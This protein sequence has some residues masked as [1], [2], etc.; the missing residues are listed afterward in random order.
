M[1]PTEASLVERPALRYFGGKWMKGEWIISNFPDHD[2]YVEPTG[3]GAN[4][5][6]RKPR[7]RIEAYNDI[8]DAVV[9]FFRVVRDK[10]TELVEA[11][12]HTP[13]AVS[14]YNACRDQV[15]SD[16]ERA[17]RFF[18]RSWGG[19]HGTNGSGRNRGWRRCATRNTAG[20]FHTVAEHLKRV[21]A[22]LRGV[23]IDCLD[24]LEMVVRWDSLRTLFYFDP[25]YWVPSRASKSPSDGYGPHDWV[26]ADHVKLCETAN[27]IR[28]A[29]VISGY[30]TPL[31]D[32]MLQGFRRIE[33]KG[34]RQ[35][36]S[37]VEVLWIREAA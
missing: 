17:R 2:C 23:S 21:A 22:R 8:A 36:G 3:G 14:E 4:V 15:G 6:L 37:S 7:S 34:K 10:C 25:P 11:L 29:V 1:T 12:L 35:D 26:E 9:N 33:G 18:V 30:P 19:H 16:V 31:Y 28:G 32:E 13:F 24:W 20:Q 5:L 27:R